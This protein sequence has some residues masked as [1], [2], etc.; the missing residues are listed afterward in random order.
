MFVALD[1]PTAPGTPAPD[2]RIR[3]V[4]FPAHGQGNRKLGDDSGGSGQSRYRKG[5]VGVYRER[6]PRVSHADRS[7]TVTA[8]NFELA[9]TLGTWPAGGHAT[10]TGPAQGA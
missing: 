2:R 4:A 10:L 9:I 8:L 6:A 1:K 3:I 5:A 7:L